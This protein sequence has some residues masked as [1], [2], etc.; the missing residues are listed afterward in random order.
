VTLGAGTKLGPY[1]IVAPIG[2][3]GMGEVY[4]A[5]DTRLG[6]EVALKVLPAAFAA[7]AERMGRFQREAKVL[8]SLNHPN[9]ASI[10]GFEDSGSTHALVMELVEG[11]TLADRIKTGTIPLDEA[12]PIA[13]QIAEGLEYAHERG[14]VHR[15]LKPA[16][17][18]VKPDGAVKI[19]DFGLAK[20]LEGDPAS[21]DISSSPTISRMATEAGIILGTAA[22]MSPEQAKGKP[23]DRRA[24]IWAFGCVLY[25]MLTGKKPFD[26]E[27][28][29]DILAA[30]V[31]AEPDWSALPTATPQRIRELL[32]RCLKKDPR[33]RLQSIGDARV[34]IEEA[35]EGSAQEVAASSVDFS[36][37]KGSAPAW[38]RV[39]P[40]AMAALMAA[41]FF[42]VLAILWHTPRSAPPAPM[43]LG[44]SIPPAQQLFTGD[45]PAVVL[46]PDGSRVAYVAETASHDQQIYVRSLGSSEAT[47]L[48][49][50]MGSSPFFSAGGQWVGYFGTDG[51]LEKVSVFGGVPV[52]ICVANSHR[53][54]SWGKDGTIVF[55][56]LV[57]APLYRVSANGGTPVAMTHLDPGR[58]EITQRWPQVLPDGKSLIFT[59]SADNNNFEHAEVEAASL[60]TGKVTVL[61]ENAYFGRYLPSG[62]LTYASG[63]TL[64]AAR[65]DAANLKLTSPSKPI[66]TNIEADITNGSAQLSISNNGTAVYSLG[67]ATGAQVRVNLVDMTGKAAPLLQQPGDYY[68]PLFS[69]DGKRLALDFQSNVWIY[70]IARGAL[71]PM[72]LSRPA[73]VTPI[74]T[75]DGKRITC[76]RPDIA[77][78][79]GL[80]WLPADGSG[81]MQPL[82]NNS[83]VR[84]IPFSWSPDGKTLAFAQYSGEG[85]ACCE[86]WTLS[87][88][89]D[90]QAGK[91]KPFL[92]YDATGTGTGGVYAPA[93]SPDGRWLAYQSLGGLRQVYVVPYPGPGGRW[94]VSSVGGAFPVWSKTGHKLFFIE[95]SRQE[96][97]AVAEVDYTTAGN[98]FIASKPKILF[99]GG[100]ISRDPYS[101]YDLAPDGKHFAMLAAAGGGAPVSAQPIVVVNW[102]A[103]VE[104]MA[105]QK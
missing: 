4:R 43:E 97:G 103:R 49:G 10:Y 53:G 57:T 99:R 7:D 66:L 40:W 51:N 76:F 59:A 74:W 26:G 87:I 3:G 54:A 91:A 88:K 100:F 33:Q 71:M 22:Y 39:L 12:L 80:S 73:C 17:V 21:M 18:K 8:A 37:S 56:P 58:K 6:R 15:D 60:A 14:I 105:G 84:Q 96:D 98:S 16:N 45:G 61:V 81:A 101:Y 23:V 86:I 25:E 75:P 64:F 69:P 102:F 24:D 78:G 95:G 55:A 29:T 46:S 63:G 82:T 94:Q 20:A 70:D 13:K 34:A 90:G 47:P 38:A 36:V 68:S 83:P 79:A 48:Q 11:P 1:E 89:A 62:Y 5:R 41:G 67:Q 50:A 32:Q 72:T 92:Q 30:V 42:V 31:R 2:A 77:T 35:V 93:F 85:R 19:L 27:T 104:R 52:T 9:I 65:F 44:L 28:V